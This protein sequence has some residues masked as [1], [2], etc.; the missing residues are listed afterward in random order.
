MQ[1][2]Q[3]LFKLAASA[4]LMLAGSAV[5]AQTAPATDANSTTST[6]AHPSPSSDSAHESTDK[7]NVDEASH[8]NVDESRVS[9]QSAVE[10]GAIAP[11]NPAA[12]NTAITAPTPVTIDSTKSSTEPQAAQLPHKLAIGKE[13]WLQVGVL[14][15]GWYDTQWRSELPPPTTYR[16]TQST[17]RMR[18]A[19]IRFIGDIVPNVAS[20]RVQLDPAATFKFST[21]NYTAPAASG[22]G[23]QTITTYVPPGNTGL[24]QDLSVTLKSPYIEASIGQ[25]KYPV[26]FEGQGSSGELYFP[27]R[28]YSSRYFGD[29]YDMGL[30]LE[31]KFDLFKYQVF[32]LNGSGQNQL[33][34]NLQKDLVVR[35]EVTPVDGVLIGATGLAS[36]GQRT[37][38][39]TTKDNVE[40]F[41]RLNTSGILIQGELLWGKKGLTA[42]G[43]ERTKAAGRYVILGYTI[44]NRL[45]PVI[46]YGYLNTDKT[47]TLGQNSSYA[48]FSPFGVATDEVRSYEVGLNYYLQ[49]TNEWKLQ[50]AYGYFDFDN[51]P[52]IQ[53][54]T[55]AAQ[56]AF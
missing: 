44:A 33:D 55:L 36:I 52:A 37:S 56:A 50:A 41:G 43:A 7:S 47:V 23:T 1:H 27:E 3:L 42:T 11:P 24:L 12:N 17:F 10:A 16:A 19:Q 29:T 34:T 30:R 13:G 46:R 40:I 32:L 53:E 15:Q 31:K 54:L 20:F 6:N 5:W 39:A 49:G 48:L 8:R 2:E 51:I 28:A 25:F 26:S 4:A 21:T 14:L 38:Q 18:R 9:V 45:Q 22:T 35:V